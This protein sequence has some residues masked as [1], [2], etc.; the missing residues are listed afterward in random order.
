[1]NKYK[2][3]PISKPIKEVEEN[4]AGKLEYFVVWACATMVV[5][6]LVLAI[7]GSNVFP[8]FLV[9][10]SY[11]DGLIANA[12]NQSFING[13]IVGGEYTL[14]VITSKIIQC[15]TVPISYAG[16]NYTLVAVECLN[17]TKFNGGK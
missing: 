7:F 12:T 8:D 4:L 14:A 2:P 1:M 5:V 9:T 15:K 6:M 3:L 10:D 13:T 16:Y 17:L 11:C